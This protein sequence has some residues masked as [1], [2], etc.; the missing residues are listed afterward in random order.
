MI[1]FIG[2]GR[3]ATAMVEGMIR[4][5]LLNSADILCSSAD[6][7]T[8]PQL[9]ERTGIEYCPD[10]LDLINRSDWL[11]LAIKPQQLRDLPP[12]AGERAM[13]KRVISILAGTR[14]ER[15]KTRFP[16]AELV[17][18]CMPNTPGQI[19]MGITA[20]SCSRNP[21]S[22]ELQFVESVLSSLGEHL[23]VDENQ[24]DAVTGV[25]GSGPAYVFEFIAALRDAGIANGLDEEVSYRLALK[26]VAGAA[27]L[28]EAVPET[29][30]THRDWV[31]SPGGTTLAGLAKLQAAGFRSLM[32]DVVNAATERSRALAS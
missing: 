15:L 7:G 1:G 12:L 17:V 5:E 27:A 24:L 21:D 28:L 14:I 23:Q 8:G 20:F 4:A 10:V 13:G 25:S 16:Y 3:M 31:S 19:G 26:T 32:K 9:A 2:S 6:D 11:V 22:A 30:E 18:R 29:P